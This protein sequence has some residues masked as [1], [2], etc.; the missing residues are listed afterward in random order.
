MADN[1]TD[2]ADRRLARATR[3]RAWHGFHP[4]VLVCFRRFIPGRAGTA[5]QK[6]NARPDGFISHDCSAVPPCCCFFKT[7][8]A[9][10]FGCGAP[11]E[12]EKRNS[13]TRRASCAGVVLRVVICACGLILRTQ[14]EAGDT[15]AKTAR[16]QRLPTRPSCNAR[17]EIQARASLYTPFYSLSQRRRKKK[18]KNASSSSC[19]TS[20]RVGGGR[21]FKRRVPPADTHSASAGSLSLHDTYC[22]MLFFFNSLASVVLPVIFYGRVDLHPQNEISAKTVC[23]MCV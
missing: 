16:T 2:L 17:V 13:G 12:H 19:T 15:I 20:T 7:S 10:W 21:G 18:R 4:S 14:S 5:H 3:E 22:F 11:A 1:C 6:K 23:D 9:M 8:R